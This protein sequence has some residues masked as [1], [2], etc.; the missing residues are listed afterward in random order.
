MINY[1]LQN[2]I[3]R[4]INDDKLKEIEGTIS[5]SHRKVYKPGGEYKEFRVK[6]VCF[7]NTSAWFKESISFTIKINSFDN[8]IVVEEHFSSVENKIFKRT[9]SKSV[10]DYIANRIIKFQSK[11]DNEKKLEIV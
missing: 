7:V 2:V 1:F 3:D 6:L 4:L 11:N 8:K 9:P 10:S 5:K